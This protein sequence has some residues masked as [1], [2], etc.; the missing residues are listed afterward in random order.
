[1]AYDTLTFLRQTRRLHLYI[2]GIGVQTVCY[3]YSTNSAR[4]NAQVAV[5]RSAP[6]YRYDL[7]GVLDPSTGSIDHR[8]AAA[9]VAFVG[10]EVPAWDP[11]RPR[12]SS[13]TTTSEASSFT[14]M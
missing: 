3:A 10:Q 5:R 7:A 12:R 8:A 6:A 4:P 2:R 13:M 11:D 14:T 1:M 9:G